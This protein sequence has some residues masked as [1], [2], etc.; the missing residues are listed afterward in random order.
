MQPNRPGI[1][2]DLGGALNNLGQAMAVQ[3]RYEEAIGLYRQAII[4][5]RAVFDRQP[6][7]IQFRQFLSNHYLNLAETLRALGRADEVAGAT[8]ER[9]RLWPG[10]PLQLY[11]LAC[12]FALCVPIAR[13]AAAGRRYADEAMGALR[14]AVAAGWSNAAHTARDPDLAPLRQ[15]P[16]FRTLLA[17]LYDRSF[18]ADPFAR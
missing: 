9:M 11:N 3:G 5:Q 10:N 16:D 6:Q 1:R 2:S 14:A 7:F 13:E 4:H 12:E 17:E 15:R 8:R 18:P